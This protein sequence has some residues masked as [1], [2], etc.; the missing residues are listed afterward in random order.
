LRSK[1][2]FLGV[3]TG[4][5]KFDVYRRADVFC[6]PTFFKCETFGI[7]LVE[8]MACGL[9]IV[10]TR[11]RAIPTI[12][13]DGQTGFLVAPQ[14][15]EAIADRLAQLA[16]NSALRKRMGYAGRRKFEQEFTF[17]RHASRMRQMFLEIAGQAVESKVQSP[18]EVLAVS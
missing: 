5:E 10:A 1:V 3:I 6:F 16:G 12:V 17:A 2:R 4:D 9:P 8:A 11:W 13:N 7:V 15:P 18:P 14:N